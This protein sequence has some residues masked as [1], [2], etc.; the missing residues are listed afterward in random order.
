MPEDVAVPSSDWTSL[1]SEHDVAVDQF[2]AAARCFSLDAWTRPL[3]PGKWSPAEITSHVFEAYRVLR[4]EL[5]GSAGM[6]MLGSSLR[7]WIL[8]RTM[9]P[10]LLAGRPFP[11]GVRAPREIRPREIQDDTAL[12]LAMLKSQAQAFTRELTSRA[13]AGPVRLTHAYFGALTPRQGLQLLTVH[14]RHHARQLATAACN[15]LAFT[16]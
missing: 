12:A 7:R 14:T 13:G 11:P 16:P 9:M 4:S 2:V 6:R 15:P 5:D 3:A 8:R 1:I 10:R